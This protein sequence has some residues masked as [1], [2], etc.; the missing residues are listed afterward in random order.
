MFHLYEVPRLVR[1]IEREGKTVAASG[2]EFA[3]WGVVV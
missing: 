1:F 2:W 3:G